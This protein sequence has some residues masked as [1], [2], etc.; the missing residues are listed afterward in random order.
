MIALIDLGNLLSAQSQLDAE[1]EV[2][3]T[4]QGN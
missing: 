1:A 2:A 4:V 3:A